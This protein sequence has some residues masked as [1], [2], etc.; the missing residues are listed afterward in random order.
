MLMLDIPTR[1][2][3]EPC[4]RCEEPFRVKSCQRLLA[5]K[6]N[7]RVTVKCGCWTGLARLSK[8]D[9]EALIRM[10]KAGLPWHQKTLPYPVVYPYLDNGVKGILH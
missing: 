2:L 4:E 7:A 3:Y 5:G 8:A 1:F 10:N 9:R 6:K